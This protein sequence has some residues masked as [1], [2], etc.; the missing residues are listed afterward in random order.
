MGVVFV[1]GE[2]DLT[3]NQGGPNGSEPRASTP[4]RRSDRISL[5]VPIEVAGTDAF[6]QFF[7]EGGRTLL[8]SRH[9]AK[10]AL[11]RDLVPDQ[12]VQVSCPSTGKSA[13][14]RIVGLISS[15]GGA[16]HYGI[17]FLDPGIDVWGIEFPPLSESEKGVARVLM[18][19][20]H[21]HA[22]ELAYLGEFEA[23]VFE[24]NGCLSRRCKRCTDTTLW[25]RSLPEAF[26]K[27]TPSPVQPGASLQSPSSTGLRAENEREGIRVSLRMAAC[28]R[29]RQHGEEILTTEDVSRGGLRFR[30]SKRYAIGWEVEVAA[31]Y[32]KEGSNI[33]APARVV[34]AEALPANGLTAYGLSYIP[35]HKGWPAR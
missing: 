5:E 18:E 26:G 8:L 10:I 2:R 32:S 16:W 27:P 15:G 22:R 3:P 4:A 11:S 13:D 19:C 24:A 31:P 29:S 12:E 17:E 23:E 35:V 25:K 1:E 7:T 30:S 9:G 28:I 33:F 20:G 6:G 21:C 14:A 34:H